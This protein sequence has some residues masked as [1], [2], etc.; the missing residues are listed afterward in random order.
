MKEKKKA[1]MLGCGRMSGAW[2]CA[3]RDHF[4]ERVEIVALVDILR[5]AASDRA[6]EFGLA[7]A[8]TGDSL[9]EAIRAT[10]ADL[11]FNCTIPEAHATT[12]ETA[13]RAG[14]D[15]LVEKP[16]ASTVEEAARLRRV[17]A[18]TGRKLAVIQNRRYLRGSVAVQRALAG[19]IVGAIQSI[20]ADFFIGPHFGGFRETMKHVLLLDMAIHTF[21]Q[22]RQIAGQ[23]AVRVACHEWNPAGS[24]FADGASAIALF[25][26]EDGAR[27]S[28]RGSWCARG[29][30]TAWAGSWRVVG[31]KGTLL[32]DGEDKIVAETVVHP[33]D[34]KEFLDPVDRHEIPV[35]DLSTAERDHVG[36]IAE[37]LDALD[38][39]R[40]SQT[41]VDDNIHSLA[42]VEGAIASADRGGAPIAIQ[43]G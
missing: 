8:W 18:E 33:W 27:F 12:C 14:C 24:W 35:A 7:H 20:H 36:N 21:D 30:P 28:Y 19:G 31:E 42:M 32:W 40:P 1:V 11:V 25:E 26:M 43:V 2:L 22:C 10:R 16:V 17:S 3:V 13:M 38:Q 15:V 9:E 5:K 4:S 34:G 29:L 6:K 37:F 23:N 41:A 39:N